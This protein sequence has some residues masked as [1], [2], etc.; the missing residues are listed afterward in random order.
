MIVN[1][2]SRLFR[3]DNIKASYSMAQRAL[4]ITAEV[5]M[6]PFSDCV[7]ICRNALERLLP[8]PAAHEYMVV[9]TTRPGIH[10]ELVVTNTISAAFP[11]DAT[12]AKVVVY[13]MG[14][15]NPARTEVDV[16][17]QPLQTSSQ[18]SPSPASEAS[19]G[20]SVEA[21]GW[22]TDF[23]LQ[24]AFSNAV[25]ALRS[26]A[27]F[28]NPD[29]GLGFEVVTMGGQVGGFTLNTGAFVTVKTV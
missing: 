1:N 20:A 17:A 25:T 21:T 23:V 29:V 14:I 2:C 27:G 7:Q 22:S 15:D 3:A 5:T 24:D 19:A 12:P 6:N 28:R 4:V 11:M 8:A 26:A 18:Q 16:G 13:S 9:G 10:P